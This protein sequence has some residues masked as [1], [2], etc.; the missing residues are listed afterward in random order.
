LRELGLD[1][2][3]AVE[4]RNALAAD[5]GLALPPT[6]IFEHPTIT[7]LAELLETRMGFGP[8]FAEEPAKENSEDLALARVRDLSEIEAMAQLTAKLAA[9][10]LGDTP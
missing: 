5:T 8:V 1:S 3:M 7:A 9:M 2:L 6:L 10:S 4:L